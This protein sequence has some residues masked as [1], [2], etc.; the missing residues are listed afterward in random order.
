MRTD[1]LYDNS[2]LFLDVLP[3]LAIKLYPHV[4][5]TGHWLSAR[6]LWS[7]CR[8][9]MS[10]VQCC[11]ASLLITM[12]SWCWRQPRRRCSCG[13]PTADIWF[14][15]LISGFF[16]TYMFSGDREARV[17][18]GGSTDRSKFGAGV[19]EDGVYVIFVCFFS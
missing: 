15:L 9:T 7:C 6:S 2:S 19:N 5:V 8:R 18:G 14:A 17:R 16:R 4:S 3:L 12:V 10:R 13:R 1:N 11:T